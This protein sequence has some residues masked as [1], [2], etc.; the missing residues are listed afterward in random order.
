[1]PSYEGSFVSLLFCPKISAV[2]YC[3]WRLTHIWTFNHRVYFNFQVSLFN[4]IISHTNN[5][6]VIFSVSDLPT[7]S[8]L[9][10]WKPRSSH[11]YML[12]CDYYPIMHMCWSYLI[13][14][15]APAFTFI[16]RCACTNIQSVYSLPFGFTPFFTVTG[17]CKEIPYSHFNSQTRFVNKQ[18]EHHIVIKLH[19]YH[20]QR[21][22]HVVNSTLI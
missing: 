13:E 15:S 2:V 9:S 17:C 11:A 4:L 10:F 14:C 20:G 5:I 1:M 8:F 21:I 12:T 18:H 3:T 6:Y 19:M 22:S 7:Y 16:V